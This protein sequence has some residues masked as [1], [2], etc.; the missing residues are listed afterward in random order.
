VRGLNDRVRAA[1][2]RAEADL[3]ADVA[4]GPATIDRA[5]AEAPA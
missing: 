5:L 2:A 3:G 1:L 4:G